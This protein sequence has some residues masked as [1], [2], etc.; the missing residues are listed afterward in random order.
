MKNKANVF[1]QSY[2][3]KKEETSH[4]EVS[5]EGMGASNRDLSFTPAT[6]KVKT[7]QLMTSQSEQI[8]F[9]IPHQGQI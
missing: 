8:R 5:V 6:W 2:M 3:T 4:S 1:N 7:L 9:K